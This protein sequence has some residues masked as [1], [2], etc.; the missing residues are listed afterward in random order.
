MNIRFKRYFYQSP[1]DSGGAPAAPAP[2]AA[3]AQS[4]APAAP[5]AAPAPAEDPTA[6]YWPADWRTKVAGDD[7]KELKHI[8]KYAT[9]ADVWKKTREME[10][11][12]SSGSLKPVLQK[13]A[14]PEDVS[15]YR[16][17]HGIPE[18][19]DKYDLSD[20]KIQEYDKEF[21]GKVLTAAHSTHQKP[22]QIKGVIKAFY[23]AVAEDR[24]RAAEQDKI[25]G[26]QAE[27]EL[28]NE[29]GQDF[30]RHSN[31]INGL[32]DLTGDAKLNE[33]LMNGR[34]ADGT[35]IKNS[36]GVQKFLLQLALINNPVGV[37][38]PSHNGNPMQGLDEEISTI[39]K[40]MR[41]DRSAYNKNEK[42]QARYRDLINAREKMKERA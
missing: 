18:A 5:A 29:W 42:Q 28:R 12:V 35:L 39:E 23:D 40:A 1:D 8:G 15:S 7:E 4:S 13:D 9:P 41:T 27:D 19:A 3:P 22:E 20:L 11:L 25:A 34:L 26:K 10:K 30:R 31:L 21:M 6:G 38:V 16:K 36:P 24:S 2:V 37:V 33:S 32:M 17:A 14:T